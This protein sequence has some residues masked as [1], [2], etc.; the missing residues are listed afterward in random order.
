MRKRWGLAALLA[1]ASLAVPAW[2]EL[3]QYDTVTKTAT[4]TTGATDTALWTPATG[5]RFVVQGCEFSSTV[6]ALVE[7]EVSD[8]DVIPPQYADSYGKWQVGGGEAPIYQSAIDA[9]LRY[10]VTFSAYTPAP[11]TRVSIVCWG[12]ETRN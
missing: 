1:L 11:D 2:A 8:V 7:L 5:Y 10:T 6:A 9:V 4:V 12:Y 3:Y